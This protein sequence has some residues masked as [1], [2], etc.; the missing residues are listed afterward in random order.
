MMVF[1]FVIQAACAVICLYLAMV[2]YKKDCR[3]LAWKCAGV[4]AVA[5]ALMQ[6]T[7]THI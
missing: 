3:P 1:L 4:A 7:R 2:N 6:F 5:I